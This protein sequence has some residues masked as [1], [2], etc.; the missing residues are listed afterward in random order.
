MIEQTVIWRGQPSQWINLNRYIGIFFILAI[1]GA[2]S[3]AGLFNVIFVEYLPFLQPHAAMIKTSIF[4]LP[5]FWACW[6]FAQ[7]KVH[8][9]ELTEEVFREHYG[10]LNR[11]T[12]ELELY[13]V[14][15]TMTLKP[16]DLNVLG[17][18]NVILHTSDAS[19]PEVFISAIRDPD[20]VRQIVRHYVEIQRTRKGIVEVS[21]R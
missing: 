18:G 10:I 9:Y 5:V 11:A 8:Y 13:R 17:L 12:Q 20:K 16:F 1:T 14:N 15:D 2:L 19:D 6:T 3:A 7:T 21:N 4:L